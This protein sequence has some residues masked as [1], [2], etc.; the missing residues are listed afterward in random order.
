MSASS[1]EVLSSS[2]VKLPLVRAPPRPLPGAPPSDARLS[3]PSNAPG[4][5][6][7]TVGINQ[8]PEP[9]PPVFPPPQTSAGMRRAS[10]KRRQGSRHVHPP[11]QRPLPLTALVAIGEASIGPRRRAFTT[12]NFNRVIAASIRMVSSPRACGIQHLLHPCAASLSS[13]FRRAV[14]AEVSPVTAEAKPVPLQK[15]TQTSAPRPLS[16]GMQAART[17]VMMTISL[18]K[19]ASTTRRCTYHET[20]GAQVPSSRAWKRGRKS[21]ARLGENRAAPVEREQV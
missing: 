19:K 7:P 16:V 17:V 2:K 15:T 21:C 9:A 12:A 14:D 4:C 11:Q 6:L 18:A 8:R 1:A 10:R 20:N 3:K 5:R 13:D